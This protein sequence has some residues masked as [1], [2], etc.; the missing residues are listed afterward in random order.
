MAVESNQV[1]V[2]FANEG[3][4]RGAILGLRGI[5]WALNLIVIHNAADGLSSAED[6]ENGVADLITAGR[7]LADEISGR[8]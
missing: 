2:E 4:A 1:K 6:R 5:F 8:F 7:K 3:D